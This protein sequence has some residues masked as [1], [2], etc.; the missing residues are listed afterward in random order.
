[1]EPKTEVVTKKAKGPAPAIPEI[2]DDAW[3]SIEEAA[4]TVHLS[5]KTITRAI[6]TGKVRHKRAGRNLLVDLSSLVSGVEFGDEPEGDPAAQMMKETRLWVTEIMDQYTKREKL[7]LELVDM[8]KQENRD[9][10]TQ[11]SRLDEEIREAH[12]LVSLALDKSIERDLKMDE[13][14]RRQKRRD[15]AI[16]LGMAVIMKKLGVSPED[17][18]AVADTVREKKKS[19]PE[20]GPVKASAAPPVE[21]T[22]ESAESAQSAAG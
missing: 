11:R 7:T 6:R 14:T 9:M 2:P 15:R 4:S 22:G 18:A 1:M 12:E 21:T 5:A 20:G 13:H 16:Q 19:D 8:V 17:F 10:R 3:V